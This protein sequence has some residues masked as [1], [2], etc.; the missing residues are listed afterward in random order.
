[1]SS[2][3]AFLEIKFQH[4][5]AYFRILYTSPSHVGEGRAQRAKDSGEAILLS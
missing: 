2:L 1:M 5:L 3:S 4:L